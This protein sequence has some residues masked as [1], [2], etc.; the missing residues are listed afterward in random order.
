MPS[1]VYTGHSSNLI[2]GSRQSTPSAIEI[3]K[4]I[5]TEEHAPQHTDAMVDTIG[6]ISSSLLGAN[7]SDALGEVSWGVYPARDTESAMP[8]H[9]KSVDQMCVVKQASA[10][11]SLLTI[12]QHH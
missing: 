1:S 9:G 6:G 4:A 7:G 8:S 3:S 11:R 2:Q 5:S 12:R 10:S